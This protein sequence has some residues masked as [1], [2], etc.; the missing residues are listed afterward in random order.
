[1]SCCQKQSLPDCPECPDIPALISRC[2]TAERERDEL[3]YCPNEAWECQKE[4]RRL[5]RELTE[6]KAEN[7]KLKAALEK[8]ADPRKRDHQEPDAY[9]ALGCVMNIASQALNPEPQ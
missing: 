3:K 8:I 6:A 2:E 5:E 7:A 9:T 4:Q 1:M